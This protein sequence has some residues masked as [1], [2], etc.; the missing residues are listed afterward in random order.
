MATSLDPSSFLLLVFH[1][2]RAF[3]LF[4]LPSAFLSLF[5][6]IQFNLTSDRQPSFP[7]FHFLS[8]LCTQLHT[9]SPQPY[10]GRYCAALTII[11]HS[12][13]GTIITHT[14]SLHLSRTV[15]MTAPSDSLMPGGICMPADAPEALTG[16][17]DFATVTRRRLDQFAWY[18]QTT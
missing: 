5:Y 12:L 17:N 1:L 2:F 14:L 10:L 16:L 13:F 8:F 9:T 4:S 6:C 11:T 15:T 3:F 18:D 7:A